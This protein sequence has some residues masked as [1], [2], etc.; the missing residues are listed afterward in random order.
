MDRLENSKPKTDK[1]AVKLEERKEKAKLALDLA[2]RTKDYNLSTSL[3]NY[4]DPRLFKS[5]SDQNT[6]DWSKIYTSAL[7]KKFRWVNRSKADWS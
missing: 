7:Q 6:M 1:Q 3:R 5:W 2:R 4:I